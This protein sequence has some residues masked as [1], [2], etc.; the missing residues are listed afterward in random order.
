[1]QKGR[2]AF[3]GLAVIGILERAS[4]VKLEL[5]RFDVG[6]VLGHS[7][8]R[9]SL[10]VGSEGTSDSPSLLEERQ[11]DMRRELTRLSARNS[12]S[13]MGKVGGSRSP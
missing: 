3:D 2:G 10:R 12:K 13:V 8:D 6:L 4:D 9:G 11:G 1:M 5:A 7:E